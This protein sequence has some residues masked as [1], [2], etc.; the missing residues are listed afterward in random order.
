MQCGRVK[1]IQAEFVQWLTNN[2]TDIRG[3]FDNLT[4]V[5]LLSAATEAS[6]FQKTFVCI[7]F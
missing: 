6:L 1:Q 7:F 5:R 3:G 2:G 4:A